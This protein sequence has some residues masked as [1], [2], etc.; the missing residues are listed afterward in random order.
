MATG[1]MN[2]RARTKAMPASTMSMARLMNSWTGLAKF[3]LLVTTVAPAIR[4]TN[5]VRLPVGMIC[6]CTVTPISRHRSIS[7]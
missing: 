4:S 3:M 6:R 7:V 2:G 5:G 1:T